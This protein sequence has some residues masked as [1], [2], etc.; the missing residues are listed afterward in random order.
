M[1]YQ[2]TDTDPVYAPPLPVCAVIVA[3]DVDRLVYE[4]MMPSPDVFRR[5]V[6]SSGA[7]VNVT[8]AGNVIAAD[9]DADPEN[10]NVT[11]PE[12]TT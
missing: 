1:A 3:P 5:A 2:P 10:V 7:V 9:A 4:V 8:A 11:F 6:S 12:A